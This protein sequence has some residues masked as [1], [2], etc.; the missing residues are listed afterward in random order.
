MWNI[1]QS[2][3]FDRRLGVEIPGEEVWSAGGKGHPVEVKFP[4]G[5]KRGAGALIPRV[6]P[7]RKQPHGPA[8]DSRQQ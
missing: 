8:D 2:L 5:L 3:T 4:N 6:R 1:E 7:A